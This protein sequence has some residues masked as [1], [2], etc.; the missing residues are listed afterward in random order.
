MDMIKLSENG[1][2]LNFDEVCCIEERIEPSYFES[3]PKLH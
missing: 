2:Y 3:S 1:K